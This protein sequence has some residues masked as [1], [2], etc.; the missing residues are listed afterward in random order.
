M[1]V[2]IALALWGLFL[3]RRVVLKR[4][5]PV[6]FIV[7]DWEVSVGWFDYQRYFLNLEGQCLRL[8]GGR[9]EF[10]AFDVLNYS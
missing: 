2:I 9:L 4:T 6:L 3:R 8:L 5:F 10:D 7:P 1:E